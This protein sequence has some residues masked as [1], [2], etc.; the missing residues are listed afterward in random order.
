MSW[1]FRAVALFGIFSLIFPVF[2]FAAEEAMP[3]EK[4]D[5]MIG[6]IAANVFSA[7]GFT[8]EFSVQINRFRRP[9]LAHD[10][11]D[12]LFGVD[13]SYLIE[14][15]ELMKKTRP[16]TYSSQLRPYLDAQQAFNDCLYLC[17]EERAALESERSAYEATLR[18]LDDLVDR[19]PGL[20]VKPSDQNP[21]ILE[22]RLTF[23]R[24]LRSSDVGLL[25]DSNSFNL[26]SIFLGTYNFP[27]IARRIEEKGWN[28][29]ALPIDHFLANDVFTPEQ[30][31]APEAKV[32]TEQL[33][34]LAN[35]AFQKLDP[36][37]V[38]AL[39]SGGL[40][41]EHLQLQL[42]VWEPLEHEV[43]HTKHRVQSHIAE[44][45]HMFRI[46][47][48]YD[49]ENDLYKAQDMMRT[50]FTHNCTSRKRTVDGTLRLGG[51][52]KCMTIRAVFREDTGHCFLPTAEQIANDIRAIVDAKTVEV[53]QE[54]IAL[55]EEVGAI[56][57]LQRDENGTTILTKDFIAKLSPDSRRKIVQQLL[58]PGESIVVKSGE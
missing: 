37:A 6:E 58:L 29:R 44:S 7:P 57:L 9:E 34:S 47:A 41:M 19:I 42:V 16:G 46:G 36:D 51:V 12:R 43:F 10:F 17:V 27:S 18:R 26:D 2:S 50:K 39:S 35:E 31:V 52:R 54:L 20:H 13:P 8:P 25:D 14:I 48:F 23:D 28:G 24:S 56:N 40:D 21:E 1:S 30:S 4:T 15:D 11:I 53:D 22:L 3:L 32:C 45:N 49:E 5:A 38:R 33:A 55:I